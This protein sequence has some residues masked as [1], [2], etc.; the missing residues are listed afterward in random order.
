MG[1]PSRELC[2]PLARFSI[3]NR[4][5]LPAHAC[6]PVIRFVGRGKLASHVPSACAVVAVILM[7]LLGATV[8]A[9]AAHDLL[10]Y[11]PVILAGD[12]A[13]QQLEQA[14][15]A[16]PSNPP[17][18][19]APEATASGSDAGNLPP[20]ESID[21]QTD[22]T[23]FLR[24]GVPDELRLAALRRAWTVD[25]AIR[26]FKGLQENESNFSDPNSVPGSGELGPEVDVKRMVAGILGEASRLPLTVGMARR[27]K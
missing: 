13:S 10:I 17:Q 1:T 11:Q 19:G 27:P 8:G 20:I 16:D 26:D 6:S 23:V 5:E 7:S 2:N 14:K 25:S 15:P 24:N 12:P 21:A 22:I 3:E 4:S 18:P 9:A